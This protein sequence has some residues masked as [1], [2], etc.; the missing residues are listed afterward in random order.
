MHCC[1]LKKVSQLSYDAVHRLYSEEEL[2]PEF[3]LFI[4][5]TPASRGGHASR[6]G[7]ISTVESNNQSSV[8]MPESNEANEPNGQAVHPAA[9]EMN[10]QAGVDSAPTDAPQPAATAAAS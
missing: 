3:K 5:T 6:G 10:E 1:E 4:P 8:E 2:P 9:D 7:N